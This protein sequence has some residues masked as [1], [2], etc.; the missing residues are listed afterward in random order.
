MEGRD[1]ARTLGLITARGGSQGLP[2]KHVLDLGG[3]PLIAWTVEAALSA[4][5]L[6]RVVVSTDCTEIAAICRERGAAVPFLRPAALATHDASHVDVIVHALDW[7]RDH[8]RYEPDYVML[9]QPTSPFR[10]AADIDGAMRLRQAKSAANVLSVSPAPVHPYLIYRMDDGATLSPYVPE[11]MHDLR[12][13]DRP[14]A[15]EM[16]GA[17]FLLEVAALRRQRTC[18]PAGSLGYPLP[19]GHGIQIDTAVDLD[20]ARRLLERS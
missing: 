18:F 2:K 12:R 4:D 5:S 16:D 7:L 3:R 6:D 1:R 14:S 17:M 13:Q 11:A 9:L 20:E 15:W 8:Q 10:D 19:P